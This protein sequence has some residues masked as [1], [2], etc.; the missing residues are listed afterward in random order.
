MQC[1]EF[2]TRPGRTLLIR[3]VEQVG[4]NVPDASATGTS[5]PTTL[6][7]ICS[8][9]EKHDPE[10]SYPIADCQRSVV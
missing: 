4:T 1:S 9:G 6:A 3:S 10:L 8:E 2:R 5:L 7:G